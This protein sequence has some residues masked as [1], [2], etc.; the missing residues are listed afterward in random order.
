MK[1]TALDFYHYIMNTNPKLIDMF[2]E[3]ECHSLAGI[4]HSDWTNEERTNFILNGDRDEKVPF[5]SFINHMK[6]EKSL[7]SF[8]KELKNYEI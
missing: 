4:D 2:L 8:K 3:N 7:K 1:I 5:K 6:G